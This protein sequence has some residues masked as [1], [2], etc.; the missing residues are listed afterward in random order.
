MFCMSI[1]FVLFVDTAQAQ[2]AG[3]RDK[4]ELVFHQAMNQ[5]SL[6]S[7]KRVFQRKNC[8]IS[9]LKTSFNKEGRLHYLEFRV[10]FGDGF[11]GSAG[12]EL[13]GQRFGFVRDY[14]KG[15]TPLIVGNL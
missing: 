1:A 3:K 10:D 15:Q 6:D 13:K 8:R 9:Y 2:K 11:S 14:R 4:V 5:R 7:V 12:A